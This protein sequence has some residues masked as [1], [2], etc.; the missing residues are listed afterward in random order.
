[1]DFSVFLRA[2]NLFFHIYGINGFLRNYFMNELIA[3]WLTWLLFEEIS[4]V[5]NLKW[6]ILYTICLVL[7]IIIFGLLLFKKAE[8]M[9]DLK[10]K[11]SANK[12]K[13]VEEKSSHFWSCVGFK[14][15]MF[16]IQTIHLLPL[17]FYHIIWLYVYFWRCKTCIYVCVSG[18]IK[19]W[20]IYK[21]TLRGL[22]NT[23]EIDLL[24]K[25]CQRGNIGGLIFG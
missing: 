10:L 1:M 8:Y 21:T 15:M 24:T 11:I 17:I 4:R 23:H 19:F 20:Y 14:L 16:N 6:T 2:W 3:W 18:Q 25:S 7:F 13:K 12:E 5:R 9:D 22:T